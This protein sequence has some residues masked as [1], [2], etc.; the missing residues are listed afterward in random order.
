MATHTSSAA[1][2]PAVGTGAGGVANG[3]EKRTA[4]GHDALD[5]AE[6]AE[7]AA[8]QA[9]DVSWRSRRDYHCGPAPR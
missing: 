5:L 1:V 6:T 8:K 7:G 4:N 2:T 3:V 9:A